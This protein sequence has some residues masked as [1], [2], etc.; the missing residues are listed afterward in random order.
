M[1][2]DTPFSSTSCH[3]VSK[4]AA[5]RVALMA[6]VSGRITAIDS[7]LL[8]IAA[9]LKVTNPV[10]LRAPIV[11]R[12]TRVLRAKRGL[13]GFLGK[14]RATSALRLMLHDCGDRQCSGCPHAHWG[15]WRLG[16]TRTGLT[17]PLMTT[18]RSRQEVVAYAR[19][20]PDRTTV[21]LVKQALDLIGERARLVD[22]IRHLGRVA[23]STTRSVHS[24]SVRDAAG[25]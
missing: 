16:R 4:A 17:R 10:K 11:R 15:V 2:T 23:R 21:A 24:V 22:G 18:V 20:A 8:R 1:N 5:L 13:G 9:E 7:E 25:I 3:D 12:R 6:S 19:H 14:P